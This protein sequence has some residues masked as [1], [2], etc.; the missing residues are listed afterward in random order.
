VV[1]LVVGAV[2]LEQLDRRVNLAGQADRLDQASDHP[3]ATMGDPPVALGPL[4]ADWGSL[5]QRAGQVGGHRGCQAPLDRQPFTLEPALA[6]SLRVT[7]HTLRRVVTSL[8]IAIRS[9]G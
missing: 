1:G 2:D 4:V 8:A 6:L 7:H 9:Y 3:D 5:K